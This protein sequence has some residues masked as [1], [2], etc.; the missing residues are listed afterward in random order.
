M[1]MTEKATP[2]GARFDQ[3]IGEIYCAWGTLAYQAGKYMFSFSG[4]A[5]LMTCPL[6][7]GDGNRKS[8]PSSIVGL[9]LLPFNPLRGLLHLMESLE[10]RVKDGI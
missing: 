9:L 5:V 6:R 1:G 7:I 2:P 8:P 4:G 10:A 3:I